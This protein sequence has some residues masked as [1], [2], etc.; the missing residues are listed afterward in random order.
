MATQNTS[1]QYSF[2]TGVVAP[3]IWNRRD[4]ERTDSAIAKGLNGFVTPT[5]GFRKRPGMRFIGPCL[6]DDKP[7][8]LVT[9]EFSKDQVYC[10]E[11]GEYRMRFYQN[12]GVILNDDNT[13]YIIETPY[14]ALEAQA[15][16]YAQ[17]R[18]AM[19]FA[20]WDVPLKKLTRYA[21]NNWVWDDVFTDESTK[22]PESPSRL[23]W[24]DDNSNGHNGY[25][26]VVTS[27][28]MES[29]TAKES[30]NYPLIRA[31]ENDID[32]IPEIPQKNILSCVAWRE[33]YQ[34]KRGCPSAPYNIDF[35]MEYDNFHVPS[36]AGDTVDRRLMSV[37]YEIYCKTMGYG[38]PRGYAPI[39]LSQEYVAPFG[40]DWIWRSSWT[41]Y[42]G[43]EPIQRS[44]YLKFEY[45]T[46]GP[47]DMRQYKS[48]NLSWYIKYNCVNYVNDPSSGDW[49]KSMV[50]FYD[51]I[52]AFVEDYNAKNAKKVSNHIMW[53]RLADVDGYYVYRRYLNGTDQKYRRV[54]TIPNG[55]SALMDWLDADVTETTVGP[56]TPIV[57]ENDFNSPDRY[58]SIV[59]F[60]QQRLVLGCTKE[61]PTTIFG[62]RTGIYTDFSIN[63]DDNASGYEFKMASKQSNPIEAIMP[64][65]TL[66]VLT[67][68]GDFISTVS[69]AMNAGN[70]NFNQ[71]SY[72]GCSP[73]DPVIV[74]DNGVYVPL[75]QQTIKAM[76]YSYEKDGFKHENILFQA[77]HYT[78][79]KKITGLAYQRDPINMIW[80]LLND[81]TLLSCLYI[82]E[83]QFLAWSEHAT[84]GEIK[85]INTVPTTE[86]NDQVYCVVRRQLGDQTFRQYI[87]Y[88]EDMRP[89]NDVPDKETAFYVDSGLTGV[90]DAPVSSI[91]GLEHLEGLEVAVLADFFV[92]KRKTVV[93]GALALDRPASVVHIGLP[94]DFEMTTLDLELA[95]QGTLRDTRRQISNCVVEVENTRELWY[96]CNGDEP[97]QLIVQM[98][99]QYGLPKMINGD[100]EL[101]FTVQDTKG[102]KLTFESHDPVPCCILSIVA[103]VDRGDP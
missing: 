9:F 95:D 6:E 97:N 34:N 63:P 82:P 19:F 92:Q 30:I 52:I 64:L 11:F 60:F 102:T 54:A 83:Q 94:Y 16:S 27:Y 13:E 73:V 28:V 91:S 56:E 32:F 17:E 57:G 15:F 103:E 21:H 3:G 8:T 33:K 93:N 24:Y 70:V 29:G 100:I 1:I 62:S 53:V 45:Y 51:K 37:W 61:K 59:T 2:A 66:A 65:Y 43:E 75:S 67:S 23:V 86:G 14:S 49:Y 85:S 98:A 76:S 84:K 72:N 41:D 40:T 5:G 74:N 89:Y 38:E 12:G 31:D 79:G 42:G 35:S 36:Y 68:G 90:F 46:G 20:H 81:G 96:S 99:D 47:W 58:P 22:R 78:R 25:E 10:L 7:V 18:D 87:E 71:K 39:S 80:A 44:M 26:Y 88:F 4:W 77:Q 69:G 50:E 48:G 101:H 55:A